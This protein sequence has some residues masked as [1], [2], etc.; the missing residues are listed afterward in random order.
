[1][2]RKEL[3]SFVRKLTCLEREILIDILKDFGDL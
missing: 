3:E 1:M 2:S